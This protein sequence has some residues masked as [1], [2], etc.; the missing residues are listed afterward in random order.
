MKRQLFKGGFVGFVE[1]MS[2]YQ[3]AGDRLGEA[4]DSVTWFRFSSLVFLNVQDELR[5]S[6]GVKTKMLKALQMS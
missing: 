2:A 3:S 1:A 4:D 5:N 6:N